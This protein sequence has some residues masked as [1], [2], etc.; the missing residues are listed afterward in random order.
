MNYTTTPYANDDY[1]FVYNVK[2]IVYQTYVEQNWGE[3]NEKKQQEYFA[4]FIQNN[5]KH[6]KIISNNHE[7]I[8]FFHGSI[9]NNGDYE[10]GNI[11]ILP[12]YQ[13][14]GLGTKIL[15][16]IIDKHKDQNIYLQY[17]K[18]NPV[19]RL[20]TRLGFKKINETNFHIQMELKNNNQRRNNHE[21]N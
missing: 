2:K 21:S 3:W 5:A 8:G 7:K 9:D 10:L 18:Q 20:Y 14:K 11:C 4:E 13:G 1:Q 16:D 6:I 19:E 15:K 17:F 12:A